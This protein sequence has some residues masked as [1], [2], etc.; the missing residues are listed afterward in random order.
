MILLYALVAK[1]YSIIESK[2]VFDY[3]YLIVNVLKIV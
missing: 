2:L 1:F 3:I